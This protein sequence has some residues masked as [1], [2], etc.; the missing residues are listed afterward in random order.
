MLPYVVKEAPWLQ[1][2]IEE[3][4]MWDLRTDAAAL[5]SLRP[6]ETVLSAK[7]GT[8]SGHAKDRPPLLRTL[9]C[10]LERKCKPDNE[11]GYR[12]KVIFNNAGLPCVP[13]SGVW[14]LGVGAEVSKTLVRDSNLAD[15]AGQHD[16][17]ANA[18]ANTSSLNN[19]FGRKFR[20]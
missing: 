6:D 2:L 14:Y 3:L 16:A 20:Q 18:N 13:G 4:Q 11:G 19:L 1:R 17:S 8:V 15:G 9:Q 12:R 10:E 5:L 7:P